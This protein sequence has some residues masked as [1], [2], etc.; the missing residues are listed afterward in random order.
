LPGEIENEHYLRSDTKLEWFKTLW[1]LPVSESWSFHG[2]FGIHSGLSLILPQLGF[3]KAQIEDANK[4][5]VDG[6][7]IGRGWTSERRHTGLALWENWAEVR[8]PLVRGFLAWD[9]FFDAVAIASEAPY[10]FANDP[11]GADNDLLDR[12]RFSMGGGFRFAI[13]QFPF[14]FLFAKRFRYED[15]ILKWSEGGL[16]GGLDFVLSFA[17]SSY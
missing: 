5:V 1:D 11:V 7:F 4:V 13:P 3:E 14:R 17:L 8:I 9:F 16:P 6:M 10:I 15:G 2:V 12:M